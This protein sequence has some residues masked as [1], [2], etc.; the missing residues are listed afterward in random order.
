MSVVGQE[1]GRAARPDPA[2]PSS[3]RFATAWGRPT[4]LL[5]GL[6]L[7]VLVVGL[8]IAIGSNPLPLSTVWSALRAPDGSF[9]A[10]V[11]DSRLPRTQLGLL[12]GAALAV[13]GC[14]IQGV[15]R[16]PLGD[17]GLLGINTGAAAA[18]VTLA[19]VSG[20]SSGPILTLVAVLGAF[21]AALVVY[22]VG[23]AG[24]AST[25]VRLVLAGAAVTAV[26]GAYIQA[27]TLINPEV[28]ATYRYWAIGS[29]V[30]Q[31]PSTV[32]LLWPFVLA[33]L[34][35]AFLLGRPLNTLSMGE[36]TAVALGAR[37]GRTRLAA[38]VVA[39]V[40]A[41][42]T[43]AAVGPIGFV[44]LA[45]P[46]MVRPFV[47]SDHRWLLPA[48]A[49]YGAVLVLAADVLGR[50]IARPSEIAVG[51]V[52]AFIGAPFLYL[53]VRHSRSGL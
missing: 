14:L 32:T 20:I 11:V 30:G 10:A 27:L 45:V 42:V 24:R 49:V 18:V 17:P 46:H 35:A 23:S 15:T 37:T 34:V 40:L 50:V 43:T 51:I 29:I 16:N 9:E 38:A 6:G 28:F 48:S 39:T 5:V 4:V 2:R 21:A 52:V 33:G 41:G 47:G 1:Q 8:S 12:V 13:S 53:A 31:H 26:T 36:E 3:H 22:G 25:P 7:L 19:A 44:G